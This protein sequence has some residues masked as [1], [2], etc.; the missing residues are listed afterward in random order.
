VSD[1]GPG[2][3]DRPLITGRVY[4]GNNTPPYP[5]PDEKTKSTIKSRSSVGGEGTNEIRFEDKKGEE[6]L[7]FHAEKNLDIQ[8]KNDRIE[9]IEND[10]HLIVKRD[11]VQ[12]TERD[13]HSL[14]DRDKI[15]EVTRD[16][17][18]KVGGKQ[19]IEIDGSRSITVK[20][21]VLEGYKANHSQEVGGDLYL[22]AMGVVIEGMTELTVK[23][24]GNFIKIDPSGV[25]IVGTMVK[26]NSGGSAGSGSMG[27][28]LPAAVPLAARDADTVPPPKDPILAKADTAPTHK[29]PTEEEEEKSW[30]EIELVDEN[31]QPVA[32]ETY[33]IELPDGSIATGRTDEKG[34]ARVSGIDPGTCKITFTN[35]DKDAWEKI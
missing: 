28:L 14:V 12:K 23:V 10:R 32:G 22:K 35:L 21:D 11:K 26:V 30:I 5:L 2:D 31:D 16:Y 6:Q 34:L 8:V 3:P 27:S 25:T 20:G 33:Q 1:G 24:G 9:K 19:A 4:N 7:L 17:S 29:D 13:E 18:L 15:T